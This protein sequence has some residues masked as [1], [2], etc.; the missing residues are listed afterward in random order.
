M[1]SHLIIEVREAL[2]ESFRH[3]ALMLPVLLAAFIVMETVNHSAKTARLA[4]AANH[5]V[6]GPIVA[7]ALGL[8]PQCGFSVVA[9][10][11]FLDGLIPTGSL[12]AA[13]IS[14]SDEAVPVLLG[15]PDTLPWV[16]PLL[17]TKLAWGAV[18]G[19]A[20][21]LAL[22]NRG[23]VRQKRGAPAETNARSP[24]HG[25]GGD[26]GAKE[27]K[28]VGGCS[29]GHAAPKGWRE[30]LSHAAVRTARVGAMVFV[31]SSV[32]H[33]AGHLFSGKMDL[34]LGQAGLVQPLVASLLGLIPSCATSVAMAEAFRAAG[35]RFRRS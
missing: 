20:V 25:G 28:V 15:N 29:V 23:R 4:T 33:F 17:A 18:A 34:A 27:G 3:T 12:L 31:L 35:C 16:L 6:F 30:Y 8:L 1:P 10:T 24:G 14:T 7:S 13:Y 2:T 11:L 21:N 9:T 26:L 5:A 32:L 19:I 22:G